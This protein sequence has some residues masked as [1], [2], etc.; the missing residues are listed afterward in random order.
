MSTPTTVPF[1]FVQSAATSLFIEHREGRGLIENPRIETTA[2][3][4]G[5]IILTFLAADNQVEQ[6][7]SDQQPIPFD[8]LEAIQSNEGLTILQVR[9]GET[10]MG[11]TLRSESPRPRD[12]QRG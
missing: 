11:Q 6:I 3:G 10:I 9:E 2:G 5:G 1:A 12:R 4:E 8:A 7:G